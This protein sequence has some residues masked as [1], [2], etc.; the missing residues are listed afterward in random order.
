MNSVFVVVVHVTAH[1][2]TKMRFVE[3]DHVIEDL[4][5][6]TSHPSLRDSILVWSK[7]S[8]ELSEFMMDVLMPANKC[9]RILAYVTGL[10]NQKLLIQ[11]E[12]LAAE[13]RILRALS[14][15]RTRSGL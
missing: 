15:V 9:A 14:V 6:T 5:P 4:A 8:H 13:N 10:V 7:N 12:Y 2:P 3:C 1:Q 11:N